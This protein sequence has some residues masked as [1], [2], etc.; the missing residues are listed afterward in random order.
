MNTASIIEGKLTFQ[1]QRCSKW[2]ALDAKLA[3]RQ[4]RCTC[5][6]AIT[7][8]KMQPDT[9]NL[10][11]AEPINYAGSKPPQSVD[12]KLVP[13]KQKLIIYCYVA[14]AAFFIGAIIALIGLPMPGTFIMVVAGIVLFCVALC[15][16]VV[17]ARQRN[18]P[19][20]DAIAICAMAAIILWPL[21]PVAL[22]WAYTNPKSQSV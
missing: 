1:C 3:G 13:S 18:H 8:P 12:S 4:A 21:W 19:Q 5:G 16:P 6:Q 10:G 15:W 14:L 20:K 2:Y 11:D 17:I 22:I 7:I 9:V